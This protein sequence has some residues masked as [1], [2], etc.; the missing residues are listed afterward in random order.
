MQAREFGAA[1][2]GDTGSRGN[3]GPSSFKSKKPLAV[4]ATPDLELWAQLGP[5]LESLV[6]M[7]AAPPYQDPVQNRTQLVAS[8]RS[9]GPTV[10]SSSLTYLQLWYYTP[11]ALRGRLIYLADPHAA[12]ARTGS[13]TIDRGYL[14]LARWTPVSVQRYDMFIA[15]YPDFRVYSAGSGWLMDELD[16]IGARIELVGPDAGGRLYRVVVR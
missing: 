5:M 8:L 13:D 12:R 10:V 11:P 7:R 15:K 14:A 4:I 9:P 2:Q 1:A 16:A 6:Q 3:P